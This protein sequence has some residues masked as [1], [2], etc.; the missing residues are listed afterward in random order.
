MSVRFCYERLTRRPQSFQRVTGLSLEQFDDVV[1]RCRPKWERRIIKP[2]KLD[3]RPSR[4]R[5][6]VRAMGGHL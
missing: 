2:K 4:P 5:G 1:L 3:G 6:R